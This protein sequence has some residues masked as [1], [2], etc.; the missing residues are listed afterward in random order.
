MTFVRRIWCNI[1]AACFS[2]FI[3]I[4]VVFMLLDRQIPITL[5]YGDMEPNPVV[6]GGK[7]KVSWIAHLARENYGNGMFDCNGSLTRRIV[8]SNGFIYDTKPEA[9]QSFHILKDKS[10]GAFTKEFNIPTMAP[11]SATYQ[12]HMIYWC[13]PIQYYIWPINHYEE[14]VHFTVLPRP[15]IGPVGPKGDDGDKGD[16]GDK[17]DTGL[18]GPR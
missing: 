3:V 1:F 14:L 9:A 7:V 15:V 16:K 5:H 13:N 8:D 12:I 18:Q 6:S 11:G 10:E 17:G 4:P 2:V